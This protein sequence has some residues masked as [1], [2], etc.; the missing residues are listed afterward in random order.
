MGSSATFSREG[1]RKF[2]G[3]SRMTHSVLDVAHPA[4][5]ALLVFGGFPSATTVVIGLV[6]AFAGFTAVFALNDVMDHSVDCE[7]MTKLSGKKECFD[8]DS[9]G[10]RHPIAQGAL[11]FNSALG[12]VVVWGL[13][14]LA[15]AFILRPLCAGLMVGALLLEIGYCRLLR[16]TH[17]KAFLSGCMVAVGGLAGVY[18]VSSAPPVGFVVLFFAWAFAWEVGCRNIPNDWSDLEED[19]VM[20]IRTFPVRYGRRASS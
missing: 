7:K 3:L 10:Y 2:F 9:V 17:W 13:V 1:A 16:V 6:A 12:W 4:I 15:L 5:G 14:S 20:K 18:V 8:I 11:T 19:V